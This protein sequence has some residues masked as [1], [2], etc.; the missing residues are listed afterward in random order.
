MQSSS[1]YLSPRGSLVS[2]TGRELTY[3]SLKH[4]L[5]QKTKPSVADHSMRYPVP[6]QSC[7]DKL[8]QTAFK[9]SFKP[10]ARPSQ[11]QNSALLLE[12]TIY[13]Q[14][15]KN[16][17]ANSRY[18]NLS[19]PPNVLYNVQQKN[20]LITSPLRRPNLTLR[21]RGAPHACVEGK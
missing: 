21:E 1:P 8:R 17:F 16:E 6:K 4:I 20:L 19:P 12:D 2:P 14:A 9:S 11:F 13:T 7:D 15:S 3:A 18:Q 5:E 10:P